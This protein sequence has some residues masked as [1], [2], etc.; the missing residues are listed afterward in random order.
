VN[1]TG[2]LADAS[3]HDDVAERAL[4]LA[5]EL[6]P[7]IAWHGRTLAQFL[8]RQGRAAEALQVTRAALRQTPGDPG[9]LS[10]QARLG[11]V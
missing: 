6:E 10:L 5:F 1:L 2:R 8:Y 11:A 7:E 9:L 4:G 3:G